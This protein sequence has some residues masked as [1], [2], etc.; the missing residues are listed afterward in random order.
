MI[1]GVS[2]TEPTELGPQDDFALMEGIA[3]R[4]PDAL[5][6]LYESH[7]GILYALCLR[8]LRDPT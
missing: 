1:V 4:E 3:K 2:S 6:R 7:S 8:I 5:E